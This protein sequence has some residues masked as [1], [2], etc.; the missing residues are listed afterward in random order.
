MNNIVTT[1]TNT[2]VVVVTA[3][4][5]SG[6]VG[7]Q[8][9]TG[10]AGTIQTNSGTIVSPFLNVN[11]S[12]IITGSLIVSGSNTFINIGPAQFTGS[13]GVSGSLFATLFSGSGAGLTGIPASGI[14]GLNLNRIASGS[15]SASVS[16]IGKAFDLIKNSNSI[17]NVDQFGN[18]SGS[19]L[20][21]SGSSIY[22][23]GPTIRLYGN[24]TLNDAAITTTATTTTDRIQ[25]GTI[26]ASVATL[27]NAFTLQAGG[28][29]I[30]EVGIDGVL[31][32]SG[33]NLFNIPASGITG[34]NL[35][36][37]ATGSVSASVNTTSDTFV[38]TSASIDLFK[39]SNTG[40]LS[41]SGA[42][43][44]NI[45]A[46]GI[47]GLN[48]SRT[49]TGS[50]SASVNVGVTNFEIISGS[51]SLL[52]LDYTGKLVV[53]KSVNVGV[54]TSNNWQS[55][56]NGSYF[57]NF[58]PNSDV[59]EI[60]RF[61]AGLLSSSA[62]DASPNTKTFANISENFSNNGT[63][64][65]P[66]GYVP[67]S[68]TTADIIYLT[69]KGFT[70]TGN[71]IFSGK[72]IYNNASYGISYSS[73]AGGSTTVSSSADAQLF[74][75][76]LLSSGNA[77]P[78]NVSGT[79]NWFYSDN[80]SETVTATSQSQNLVS[81]SSFGTS[82]GVTIA[83]IETV[84]PTVIPAAYQDGKFAT[85][86]SSGLFNGGRSF[87]S[88]SSS[89]WYHISASITIA[90]G[91][92]EYSTA[93]T[94]VER[95]FWAP[96]S[97][98]TIP[99]QTITF[100]GTGNNTLTATSRSLSG[101]PY[102]LTSTFDFSTTVNG[103]FNPLYT[104]DTTIA[105]VTEVDSLVTLSGTSSV[106]TTGGTIQT[107]TAVF[108][109]TGTTAR[110]TGTVPFETDIVKMTG[111]AT[112]NAGNSGA[113]N[114]VTSNLGT[115]SFVLTH[116]GKNRSGTTTSGTQ[117]IPYHTAGTFGQPASSGSLAYYGRTSQT[118][119]GGSLTG[120][121]EAFTGEAYR[122]QLN[123]NVTTFTGN[124]WN[125]SFGLYNL[126]EKDLQVKPGNLVRPGGAY[127]YWLT[128]PDNTQEYKYYIRRFQKS[129]VLTSFTL[130][131]GKT[132]VPWDDTSSNNAVAVGII[133]ES[134]KG[135][136]SNCRL[137]DPV[138]ANGARGPVFSGATVGTNPFTSA[139]DYY[140]A[141]GAV[142]GTTYTITVQSATNMVLNGTAGSDEIYVIIRYKGDPSPVTS[143]A[144][145][146]T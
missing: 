112:F 10:S 102:L 28:D 3:P 144:V 22:I 134:A 103:L 18:I 16:P 84:N 92:S 49:A 78:F 45:P 109:S 21:I 56:L 26:T 14:S 60:L 142:S 53:S 70:S 125:N 101:A 89:G 138:Y 38:L 130:N 55:G 79:I 57:N 140:G 69:S 95:I 106:S 110:S 6:P 42:N 30:F 75:L 62:P 4:G 96:V 133:F 65:A 35:S 1:D 139:L 111:S 54:P 99:T 59:S 123:D 136:A 74:G 8:G 63:T 86:F 98:I 34:L 7:P 50:V 9:P 40:I 113:T 128:D 114:I 119:D 73:T 108:D 132:L 100:S 116:A 105:S 118:Y 51:T 47:T 97:N 137:F 17:F 104:A 71:T 91:S 145:S 83:K 107:A 93:R 32:G 121:T 90:T 24:A 64:T 141:G 43:L 29:T 5:P 77:T 48:L 72:T 20:Y 37:T 80:N 126:G 146:G 25:S 117:T 120:Q 122:I 129:S 52:S 33:A 12:T 19:G 85:A 58:T 31:S 27:G 15:I 68:S 13:V 81:N 87:T 44:F 135:G 131:V 46:S 36:R 41:G 23:D 88:V 66:S 76:G 94:A 143:L 115:T 2:N 67:Q 124:A 39:I 82:N 127:G 11:G 61:I